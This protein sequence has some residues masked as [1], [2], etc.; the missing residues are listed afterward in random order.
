MEKK[1]CFTGV[2]NKN[3][4][5]REEIFYP[6][7]LAGEGARRAGEGY[8][9]ENTYLSPLIGFE[10]YRTQNHFPRQGGSQTARGFTLIE[11]LV[12]VLII[13]ILA[14]VA[15]P[16]YRLSVAKA[17]YVELKTIVD[18]ITQAQ[19]VYYLANGKYSNRFEE[20]DIDLPAGGTQDT[21]MLS[22][23]NYNWGFCFTRENN[24]SFR[25]ICYNVDVGLGY[26]RWFLPDATHSQQRMCYVYGTDDLT[27]WR[28]KV[29]QQETKA[30]NGIRSEN[31]IT[32]T[33]Q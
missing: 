20:L 1:R 30:T 5:K 17:R 12:V 16:Q 29:C 3:N 6:S 33:Y 15:L 4:S 19:E 26:G 18:K 25:T 14:A 2:V 7:P 31:L 10:C 24:G 32:W 21:N 13:G 22:R 11:L 9:K 23:Y 28:N 8:I 27:D